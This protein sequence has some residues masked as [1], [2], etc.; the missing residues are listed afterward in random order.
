MRP[1]L[2]IFIFL[3]SIILEVSYSQTTITVGTG[4]TT[5]NWFSYPS[6]YGKRR[7]GAKHQFIIRASELSAAGMVDGDITSLAFNVFN[8]GTGN[9]PDFTIK[10]KFTT[11]TAVGFTFDGAGL[12]TVYGPQFYQETVGWNTHTLSSPFHWDGTSNILIETCFYSNFSGSNAMVYNTPTPFQSVIYRAE[13]FNSFICSAINGFNITQSRP[14]MQFVYTPSG[15]P[16]SNFDS[17]DQNTCGSATFNNITAGPVD[18]SIW[19]YGDGVIDTLLGKN[20]ATHS[21]ASVGTYTVTLTTI[22]IN[23]SHTFTRSNYI[24]VVSGGPGAVSCIPLTTA[25]C[26]GFGILNVT[27][28]SI[29]KSSPN[30]VEGYKD[31]SCFSTT[32]VFAGQSYNLSVDVSGSSQ[33]GRQDVVAWIDYNNDGVLDD[34]SEKVF[35]ANSV[36][37][38]SGAIAIPASAVKNTPLRMRIAAD[39]DFN[40][41]DSACADVQFGQVEDY[42]I[43]VLAN[44]SPPQADFS[45]EPTNTCDGIVDFTDASLNVPTTW[46][47][48]FG[49]GATSPIQHPSYTYT[50]SGTFTVKLVVSNSFGNDVDSIVNYI[51]VNLG[52]LVKPASC[53]PATLAYCCDYGITS[54]SLNAINNSTNDGVDDFQD[55]SCQH[56]TT[57][58]EGTNYGITVNMGS[59]NAH[60]IKV[61]LDMDNNGILHDSLEL[62]HEDLNTNN[63]TGT[64]NIPLGTAVYNTPLRMRISADFVG[65]VL[66]P[67]TSPYYG[68]IEDYGVSIQKK[69][70]VKDNISAVNFSIFPNPGRGIVHIKYSAPARQE[71]KVR[72]YNVLG[73]VMHEENFNA[74]QKIEKTWDL[75]NQ[76]RGIYFVELTTPDGRYVEMVVSQ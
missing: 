22:N 37:N 59:V 36:L 53:I 48:D 11:A 62:I 69:V 38:A 32:N 57:I 18:T 17:Q 72:I 31:F 1:L 27:F 50:S 66:D 23:G 5:N 20:A 74:V 8:T 41:I 3:L 56:Q 39:Y 61:W 64:I 12:T 10:M 34:V 70:G 19:N 54:V 45:A 51:T 75:T 4:T 7:R 30:G 52:N 25:Y 65:N 13:N 29:N 73:R 63:S 47:W 42:S 76:G 9:M 46:S 28:N 67:C 15:P 26:C 6:P 33:G 24:T 16:V 71:V 40:N 21:Y 60:D 35:F 43:T 68:Q 49:D 14:N 55:Y 44:S 58:V 2:L